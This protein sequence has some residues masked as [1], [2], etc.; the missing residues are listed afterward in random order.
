MHL[1]LNRI[2]L[3][4]F[5]IVDQGRFCFARP[6]ADL[7]KAQRRAGEVTRVAAFKRQ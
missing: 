4:E 5:E 6:A 3:H 1:F 7:M 2:A